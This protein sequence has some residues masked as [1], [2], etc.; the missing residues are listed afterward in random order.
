M[1]KIVSI[2]LCV[3]MLIALL[4]GC[5]SESRDSESDSSEST[6]TDKKEAKDLPTVNFYTIKAY[7]FTDEGIAK[8]EQAMSEYA[9][10]KYG[11]NI[12]LTYLD[13]G[14]YVS[15]LN[16]AMTSSDADI[17]TLMGLPLSSFVSN[18]QL[19]D[20]TD[21][22]ANSSDDLKSYFNENQLRAVTLEEKLYAM[23]R[24]FVDGSEICVSFNEEM[25][26]EMGID[27]QEI[28]TFEKLDTV[29]YEA[30]EKYPDIYAIVPQNVDDMFGTAWYGD[31]MSSPKGEI[32]VVDWYEDTDGYYE[33]ESIFENETFKELCGYARKW[34]KDG[35]TMSDALSNTESG[36]VY[37]SSGQAFCYMNITNGYGY[38]DVPQ[39]GIVSSS[40]FSQTTCNS[41]ALG[42][43]AYAINVNSEHPDEAWAV[44]SGMFSDP[45][46]ATYLVDGIEG[47]T[48]VL[49]EDGTTSYPEGQDMGN[50][51]Y[52]GQTQDF[53]YPNLFIA[54]PNET[55]G[56]AYNDN[57]E[58]YNATVIYSPL[59]GFS[60]DSS[61]CTDEVTACTNVYEKYYESMVYGIV[62]YDEVI[63][64]VMAEL[65][66]AGWSKICEEEQRQ[67]D[68]FLGQTK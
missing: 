56:A 6:T 1:K 32:G 3:V 50:A 57:V 47:E 18:N 68:E 55:E 65:D 44:L 26:T 41:S 7:N 36:D 54:P 28:N 11:C 5:G 27:P 51:L 42:T 17:V 59:C 66:A 21:Y 40:P 67:L 43:V 64:Q 48:Y 35:L 52:A 46:F 8:V 63:E 33:V 34:Y 15:Q 39:K 4:V 45:E 2:M 16:L 10:E 60:F 19:L 12:K 30:H 9:A 58:A 20:L 22:Y 29:L 38:I 49:N 37:V 23:P 24:L 61:S 62:E 25:V 31:S 14:N 53:I 13:L